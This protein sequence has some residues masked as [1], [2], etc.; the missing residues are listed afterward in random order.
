MSIKLT[1]DTLPGTVS[2]YAALSK[3][4]IDTGL[5][6]FSSSAPTEETKRCFQSCVFFAASIA[7]TKQTEI[8][9]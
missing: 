6:M 3:D 4:A 1:T 8:I 7:N 2:T 9:S 5:M